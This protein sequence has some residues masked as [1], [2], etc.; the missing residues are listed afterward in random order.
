MAKSGSEWMAHAINVWM[1]KRGHKVKVMTSAMNNEQYE[2]EGIPV[3]NRTH[4]WYFHHEWADII[5]TQLDFAQ[6]V[7]NDCKVSKKPG[8]WFAHNTFMYTSVR[9]N[10]H[11]NVVYNSKWNSEFC[12][13]DNNGFV[14]PPPVD[15][16]HYRVEKGQEI[17]LINLN[18]NKGAEMFYRIAEAMPQERFLGVQGGYG[19]QIYKELPNVSYMANQPDIRNAYRRTGILLMPSQYESWGRTATEAMASGIP[20]IVSDLPGLRE[21]CGDAAIYCR[22]DRL[23]DWTAAINN[24][25]NNYEFYTHK[26]LQRA[27]ELNPEG[28]LLNFEQWVTNLTL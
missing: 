15:I 6:D 17:T 2:Y 25:R 3:F 13:Y 12:K 4:D 11:L 1:L 8:V 16:D 27:K 26:S 24:V 20:V 21:N 22:P 14:L 5:F 19:Q 28:N 9:S 23:E 7:V 18:K 10:R